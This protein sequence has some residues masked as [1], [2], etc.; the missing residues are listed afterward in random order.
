[1]YVCLLFLA[2]QWDF[3]APGLTAIAHPAPLTLAEAHGAFLLKDMKSPWEKYQQS[4][5]YVSNRALKWM[6]FFL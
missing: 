5:T 6:D 1:M 4:K 3:K 2:G